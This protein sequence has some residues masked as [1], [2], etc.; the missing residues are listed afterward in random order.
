MIIIES[1]KIIKYFAELAAGKPTPGS[2]SGA[3]IS[4]V[5]AA[6]LGSMSAS[7]MAKNSL[8]SRDLEMMAA[9][10]EAFQEKFFNLSE[11]DVK[12]FKSVMQYS[13]QN[14]DDLE[15]ALEVAIEVPLEMLEESLRMLRLFQKLLKFKP[16][17]VASEI[18][19]AVKA[20]QTTITASRY[21]IQ[22]NYKMLA[23][24]KEITDYAREMKNES[25]EMLEE[26]D[27]LV[28]QLIAYVEEKLEE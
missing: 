17:T 26:C 25:E 24:Q 9:E 5:I 3:G 6:S 27:Q 12:A 14:S 23:K 1:Q 28:E 13:K 7:I 8:V 10:F 11:Q 4:A 18:G 21:N 16:D 22:A 19:T 15:K 2:G 20:L